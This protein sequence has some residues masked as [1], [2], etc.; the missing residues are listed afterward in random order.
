[1]GFMEPSSLTLNLLMI[2]FF[3]FEV[4]GFQILFICHVKYGKFSLNAGR[5]CP[6]FSMNVQ[7]IAAPC[8]L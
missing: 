5:L 4:Q 6:I 7:K 3:S 8:W 1:M 2:S